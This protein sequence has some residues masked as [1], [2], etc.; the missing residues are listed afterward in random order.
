MHAH[1]PERGGRRRVRVVDRDFDGDG[2]RREPDDVIRPFPALPGGGGRCRRRGPA[3]GVRRETISEDGDRRQ[4]AAGPVRAEQ[5]LA[6]LGF[7]VREVEKGRDRH[8]TSPFLVLG[9][10][11]MGFPA[12]L[13]LSLVWP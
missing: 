8:F 11:L 5:V 13:D 12:C 2:G 6:E 7:A 3:L 1:I 4:P 10:H 9:D